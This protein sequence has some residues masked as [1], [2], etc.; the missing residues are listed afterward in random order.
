MEKSITV[1]QLFNVKQQVEEELTQTVRAYVRDFYKRT[2]IKPTCVRV[3]VVDSGAAFNAPQD[4][5]PH[6][7]GVRLGIEL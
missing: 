1:D 4:R 6:V 7:A 2:G 5:G 3:D